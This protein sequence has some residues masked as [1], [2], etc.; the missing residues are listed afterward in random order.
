MRTSSIRGDRR[1][2]HDRI[3]LAQMAHCGLGQIEHRKD[4]RSERTLELL[5][6]DVRD[7]LLGMLFGRVVHEDVEATETLYDTSDRALAERL[8]ADVPRDKQAPA[9]LLFDETLR[10]LRVIV[11]VQV[12]DADIGALFRE[13][14][15]DRAPDA[16][17]AARD[18][19]DLIAQLPAPPLFWVVALGT[20]PHD[21]LAARLTSLRLTRDAFRRGHERGRCTRRAKRPGSVGRRI[22]RRKGADER[23]RDACLRDQFFPDL[24]EAGAMRR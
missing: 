1:R 20:W 5:G 8:L 13:R 19:R 21:R 12:D 6:R 17:V 24:L 4:V 7:L 16:A 22:L 10:L 18:Q 9:T 3:A 14:D 11:L 23:A 2:I 15:R